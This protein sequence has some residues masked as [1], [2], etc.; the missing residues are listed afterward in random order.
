VPRLNLRVTV[1]CTADERD[2]W[3]TYADGLDV[4]LSL[5]VRTILNN[6]S[7]VNVPPVLDLHTD[8]ELVRWHA[9]GREEANRRA[10]ARRRR[11]SE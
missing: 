6:L 1:R 8:A 4:D 10:E 11:A 9:E 7:G 2:A 5:L 3:H